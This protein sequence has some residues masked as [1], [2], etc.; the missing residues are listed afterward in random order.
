MFVS[1]IDECASNPC[2]NEA[3]CHNHINSYSC[4][5]NSGF[6]GTNCEIGMYIVNSANVY[7]RNITKDSRTLNVKEVQALSYVT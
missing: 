1:D 7:S 6:E 2:Q 4:T 5:C 3:T